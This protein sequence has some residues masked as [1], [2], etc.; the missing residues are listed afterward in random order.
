MTASKRIDGQVLKEQ[1]EEARLTQAQ[2]AGFIGISRETVIAIEKGHP[3][4]IKKL[5]FEVVQS[6][7]KA[8]GRRVTREKKAS[9]YEY[10]TNLLK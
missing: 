9:F 7:S 3:G 1:R 2:L 4:T 5:S 6:W 10:L 8:C